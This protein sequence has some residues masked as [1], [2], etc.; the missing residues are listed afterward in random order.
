MGN[1]DPKFL[2]IY[3]QTL[4]AAASPVLY[5]FR[6]DAMYNFTTGTWDTA[7][8]TAPT[9][10]HQKA[11]VVFPNTNNLGVLFDIFSAIGDGMYD[12]VYADG[13]TYIGGMKVRLHR[14][15]FEVIPE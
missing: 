9:A 12:L 2:T 1:A 14:D 3:D 5:I 7:F 6:G 13:T 10:N 4:V 15:G 11:G 8:S